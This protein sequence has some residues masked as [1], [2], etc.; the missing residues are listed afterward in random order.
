MYR[1]TWEESTPKYCYLWVWSQWII[2]ISIDFL[3]FMIFLKWSLL[4]VINVTILN[5]I[6]INYVY[7]IY[8]YMCMLYI[9]VCVYMWVCIFICMYICVCL[10]V[11]T[12]AYMARFMPTNPKAGQ[13]SLPYFQILSLGGYCVE[14]GLSSVS[15]VIFMPIVVTTNLFNTIGFRKFVSCV[16]SKENSS[17]FFLLLIKIS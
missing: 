14:G 4:N 3:F 9:C 11:Y 1:T 5:K 2:M 10:C 6:Y 17:C 13:S 12:C 16:C 8:T 7:I 15:N